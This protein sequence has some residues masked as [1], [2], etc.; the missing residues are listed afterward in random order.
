MN[1]LFVSAVAFAAVS[2]S[3]HAQF[4]GAPMVT[5]DPTQAAH[6]IQQICDS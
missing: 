4:L 1:N 5:F 3:A 6:V 2:A